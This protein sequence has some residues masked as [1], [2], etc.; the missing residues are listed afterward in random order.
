MAMLGVVLLLVLKRSQFEKAIPIVALLLL[1][2]QRRVEVGQAYATLPSRAFYPPLS[3]LKTISAAEPFRIAAIGRTFI[4]EMS[5]LYEL[6]DVR[7]D[8]AM[9][10]AHL[11]EVVPLFSVAQPLWFNRIDD[12]TKPFL[13]FLNVRYVIAPPDYPAPEGWKIV[14]DDHGGRLLENPN[15]LPRAFVPRRVFRESDPARQLELL[16]RI[17]DFGEEGVVEGPPAPPFQIGEATVRIS[18]YSAQRMELEID[19]RERALVATSLT[20]WPGWQLRLDGKEAPLLM[21]NRAFLA[22]VLPPGRHAAVLFYWPRSFT[23]G[24]WISAVSLLATVILF[25]WPRT[26][27]E[28]GL[29]RMN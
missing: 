15:V 9:T 23:A 21:Y 25:A 29:D 20:G 27:I 3:L 5:A 12:P 14:G 16:R 7:G 4:P 24:L 18:S 8:G 19:A 1:L 26:H 28:R 13:N 22:F 6:E 2:A 10:L 17:T 11:G